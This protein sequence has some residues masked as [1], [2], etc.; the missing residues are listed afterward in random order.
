MTI[1]MEGWVCGF[2]EPTNEWTRSSD[3]E[4][5]SRQQSA[6]SWRHPHSFGDGYQATL[7]S[8]SHRGRA[9]EP[10]D[11]CHDATNGDGHYQGEYILN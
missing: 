6:L 1:D 9:P 5:T 11:E 7:D 4:Q 2:L 10:S 3:C 8:G